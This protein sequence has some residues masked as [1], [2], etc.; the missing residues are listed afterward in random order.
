[1]ASVTSVVNSF[2]MLTRS[3]QLPDKTTVTS[4]G[5]L[6]KSYS[7]L[8][9]GVTVAWAGLIFYLSTKT[10]GPGLSRGLLA[11]ALH[12]LKLGLAPH[13]LL[14]LDTVLRKLAHLAEYGIFALLLYGLPGGQS[15]CRWHPRRAALCILAAAAYSLTDEFHQ[16]FVPGRHASLLDCGLDI[17][18]ASLA[19]LVRL[20][21]REQGTGSREKAVG[22]SATGGS[23][24]E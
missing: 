5:T 6:K 20:S 24:I 17:F 23:R 14:L 7:A 9:W 1:M 21:Y 2:C 18:G 16:L 15:S 3:T 10:F 13:A 12:L 22:S 8:W 11:W 19:M 4:E